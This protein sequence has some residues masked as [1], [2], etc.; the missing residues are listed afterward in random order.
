MKIIKINERI[1]EREKEKN[2][3]R[4]ELGKKDIIEIKV[5]NRIEE[6]MR[7]KKVWKKK[8]IDGKDIGIED[9]RKK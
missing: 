9:W 8:R 4:G 6:I 3:E 1:K 2:I 7:D 5:G